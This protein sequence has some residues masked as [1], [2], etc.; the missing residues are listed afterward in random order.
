MIE[1]ANEPELAI[2]A[3]LVTTSGAIAV[4]NL[5][6]QIDGLQAQLAARRLRV[7]RGARLVDLLLLRGQLLGRIA[8]YERA[9]ALAEQLV[10]DAPE[11]GAA[12]LAR[13]RVRAMLHRF[14][15]ALADLDAAARLGADPCTLE[16]ERAALFQALG[17][18]D[19][20]LALRRSAAERRPGFVALGALAGLQADRGWLCEAE[21]LFAR[22]RRRYLGVSP[23]PLALLDFQR[24]LMW[25][26]HGDLDAARVWFSAASARVPAYAGALG[27]LAEVDIAVGEHAAAIERLQRIAT[28]SDDPEYA[29]LLAGV[30]REAGQAEAASAWHAHAVAGY[31]ALLR[32]HPAAFVDHAAE[33]WLGEGG[34]AHRALQLARCNLELRQTP[35]AAALLRRAERESMAL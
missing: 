15:A 23:F 27:H 14:D 31:D 7:E 6:A 10:C 26:D 4:A 16:D 1:L 25:M 22:A 35:R 29:G 30:L 19:D 34:D 11:A 8:D 9:T 13:A 28:S 18:Y 12:W 3:E 20:A 33:F 2:D 5:Q 17:H 32:R 24:G 21:R